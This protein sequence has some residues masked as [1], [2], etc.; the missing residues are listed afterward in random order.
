[1]RLDG[2][3]KGEL[4][5]TRR[6][7]QTVQQALQ[8]VCLGPE[9]LLTALTTETETNPFLRLLPP[10]RSANIAVARPGLPMAEPE[11]HAPGLIE[12]VLRQVDG[13]VAR[14]ED[15]RL[16][17][18]LIEELDATGYLV[19]SL[20]QIAHRCGVPVERL[21]TVLPQMRRA[22]PAGLFARDLADCLSLQLEDE[23]ALTPEFRRLLARLPMIA[24]GERP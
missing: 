2:R 7:G 14:K 4:R 18:A 22:E 20:S 5:Q 21:E 3:I 9:D 10:Q 8:L 23:G 16:A 6:L 19:A 1:M 15:R 24:A 13:L 12:H 17:R 11:A